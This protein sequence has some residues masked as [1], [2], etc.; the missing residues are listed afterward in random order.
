MFSPATV[1]SK[2]IL[3]SIDGGFIQDKVV[4][5]G[6]LADLTTQL[7]WTMTLLYPQRVTLFQVGD[8]YKGG[9]LNNF[10][11]GIDKSYCDRAGG[12]TSPPD[13]KYPDHSCNK[14]DYGCYKGPPTCG[15]V[16]ATKVI[17]IAT[18][19]SEP[20]LTPAYERRQC[21]EYMKVS[22]RMRPEVYMMG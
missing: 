10:L 14:T 17:S 4:S 20:H 19:Y 11:D 21:H 6:W 3:R 1:G 16:A 18:T 13:K 5:F 8:Y 9:S 7:E 15:G 22:P 2:P 12:D